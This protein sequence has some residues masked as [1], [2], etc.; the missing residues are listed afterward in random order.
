[1]D[2][3]GMRALLTPEGWALLEQLPPY[4]EQE[5]L[6]LGE[7]LRKQGHAPALVAAALTQSRLRARGQEKLGPF[8]DG[9]LLTPD[10]LEQATRL[11]VAAHHARRFVSAGV[12]RVAD[13]GCGLGSDAMALA[14]LDRQVLAI[15][16]DELTAAFATVNLRHWPSAEVRCHDVTTLD[17]PGMLEP[18][19]G[20]WLDPARRVTGRGGRSRR[21]FDP[22]AF[23]PPYSFV[24]DVARQFP[25]TGAKLAP[26]IAHR[27]LPDGVSAPTA[28][29][30][31]VSVHGDVVECALWFGPLARSG[32]RRSALVLDGHGAVHELADDDVPRAVAGEVG[33]FV[34]EPDGAVIRAGLVPE[35]AA[36]VGARLI[37]ATIAYLTT[38]T[39][40]SDPLM[41]SY[42]VQDVL[43]YQVKTLRTY[44]RDRGVGVLTIKKRGSAVDPVQLRRQL[45][46]TGDAEA[47]I[48]LTRVQGRPSVL[49][50]RLLQAA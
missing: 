41:H 1:M 5:S 16:A 22:E 28:E 12:E 39:P 26:G 36:R 10:G 18:T 9:M 17:L 15:D 23:S 33:A 2:L 48:A 4:D 21:T 13:L 31:W 47:T 46:L 34:H 25:A 19:D 44:L 7:R 43:P 49:V 24:L 8:A 14:A 42:A 40:V 6:Q 32:V 20:V 11:S 3:P 50:L 30:Q 38:D 45:R 37:D 27:L 35:M 29:A